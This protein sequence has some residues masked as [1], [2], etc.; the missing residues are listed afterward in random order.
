MVFL[1]PVWVLSLVSGLSAIQFSNSARA[2]LDAICDKEIYIGD[3]SFVEQGRRITEQLDQGLLHMA[4][5]LMCSE[6][7][8]CRDYDIDTSK[9]LDLDEE[10]LNSYGR[11]KYT[12]VDAR[13]FIPFVFVQ[14]G[15]DERTYSN[16]D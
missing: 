1:L 5:R 13:G 7:C 6:K 4:S 16:F 12:G 14:T 10:V 3:N 2:N 15:Y 8:P 11:T 9:W